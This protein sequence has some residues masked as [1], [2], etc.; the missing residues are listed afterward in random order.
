MTLPLDIPPATVGKW[1]ALTR[2]ERQRLLA[3]FIEI[4]EATHEEA[5]RASDPGRK[6]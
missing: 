4:I 3:L 1:N 5:F 6:E 2:E